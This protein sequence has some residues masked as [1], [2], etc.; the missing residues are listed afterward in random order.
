MSD[1]YTAK[2]DSGTTGLLG[3][4]R[5]KKFDPRMEALGTLDEL[6]A[7]LGL[8]RSICS[9][10]N[11]IVL[12]SIQVHLYEIMGEVAATIE[13]QTQFRKIFGNEV[14][15]LEEKI[16]G[17]SKDITL[18]K[19]FIL[20]GDT[21]AS[22]AISLARTITRRAERRIAELLDH[23]MIE[24]TQLLR[25]LNRLSS[26]LFVLELKEIADDKI[27]SLSLAKDGD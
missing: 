4:E 8:A 27:V 18:P 24:N 16:E 11:A 23:H 25:Y 19:G 7:F 13:N 6:S 9:S 21:Q 5:V 3:E 20:P 10:S 22:A 1:F 17:Y 26:F 15:D 2:G 12:K 14:H